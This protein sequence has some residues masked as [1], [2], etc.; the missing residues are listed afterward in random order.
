VEG[1]SLPDQRSPHVVLE[2]NDAYWD[3]SRLPRLRRVVFDN[4]IGPKEAVELVKTS[5][6]QVDLVTGLSP[7]ET[8]RVA[9]SPFAM[10]VK[11]RGG[12]GTVFGRFNM[13]KP[14]SPWQDIRVRQAAN[15]SMHRTD[16]TLYATK[17]NGVVIPALVPMHG[18]G[19]DPKLAPYPF[20]P[21]QA[22]HLLR[23]AG[24]TDGLSITLIAPA[25]LEVQA[26]VVSK[27]LAQGGFTVEHHVLDASAYTRRTVLSHLDH[28]PALQTW[29]IALSSGSDLANF[30]VFQL[31]HWFLLDGQDDW[32]VEEPE[33]R[34][35][36]KRA[37]GSVD[38]AQQQALIQQMERYTAEQAYLLFLYNPIP[39]YAVNKDVQF[40]PY[41]NGALNLVDTSV[42]A[43]HWSVRQQ[44]SAVQ[45]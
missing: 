14:G 32:V 42:T 22:R 16:L 28:P 20:D 9:Q 15:L 5:E 6:G 13:R 27:M 21:D 24:Y 26:T 39:L 36:Y 10:V 25:D 4:T 8:L 12:L 17:G 44:K 37:L 2:A 31:Y 33:L 19:F 30:P 3:T 23:E 45:E 7:L 38:R 35:L 18:F 41:V 34:R 29:D 1:F 43:Q 40:V 11:N